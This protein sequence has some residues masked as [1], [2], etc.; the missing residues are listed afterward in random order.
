LIFINQQE[1]S[2][3]E[4][5]K[6]IAHENIHISQYH[7][8]DL[9]VVELVKIILWFNPVIW[10]VRKA[11][12]QIHEYQ[13]DEGV[14][15][16]GFDKLEYQA[17]LVNQA[18]G[19][20]LL[21]ISPY[22][23]YSLIKK[24]ILMMTKT[25]NNGKTKIR[26]FAFIPMIVLT[27]LIMSFVNKSLP[28]NPVNGE[29]I[30]LKTVSLRP[31]SIH[32]LPKTTKLIIP[33]SKSDKLKPD[34]VEISKLMDSIKDKVTAI[35]PTRMNVLY[36]GVSNPVSIAVSGV[37]KDQIIVEMDNGSVTGENGN[38]NVIPKKFGIVSIH[39]FVKDKNGLKN[40]VSNQPFKV[41]HLPDPLAVLYGGPTA[42]D[43]SYSITTYND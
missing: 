19:E 36:F 28:D 27:F 37:P 11:L 40:Q 17:L 7:T 4:L 34:K 23:S 39:V 38:Y 18:A 25:K 2:N 5:D 15:N 3:I 30:A 10:M 16:S 33:E 12:Q 1:K 21:T 29:G 35:S 6:I 41:K 9:I 32:A 8:I 14:L 43:T 20:R 31:V 42:I 13:A 26:L 22:F 24:R